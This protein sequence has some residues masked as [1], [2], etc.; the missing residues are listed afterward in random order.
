MTDSLDEV[1]IAAVRD[2]LARLAELEKRRE[3]ILR[4]LEERAL[5][6]EELAGRPSPQ[7]PR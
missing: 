2:R 3:A 1:Q 6:T 5:L 7:P 4:S